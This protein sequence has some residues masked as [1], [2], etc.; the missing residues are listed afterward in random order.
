MQNSDDV[1]RI[2]YVINNFDYAA[3]LPEEGRRWNAD[4]SR[5]P[6]VVLEK[7]ID[8]HYFVAEAVVDSK[9]KTIYIESAYINNNVSGETLRGAEWVKSPQR[10]SVTSSQHNSTANTITLP[11]PVTSVNTENTGNLS[12]PQGAT[13]VNSE[14]LTVN[15]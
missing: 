6:T 8:G 10:T 5:A 3:I 2:K 13:P 9:Q 4:G 11:Q 14:H 7:R 12:A 15:S 1:A